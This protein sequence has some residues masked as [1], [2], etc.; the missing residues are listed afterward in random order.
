MTRLLLPSL[1][2]IALASVLLTCRSGTE[3]LPRGLLLSLA[4][5]KK[6]NA[7]KPVPLP[8]RLGILRRDA[9][10][11]RYDTIDDPDSNV[12]HKA[13][14]YVPDSGRS[15]I[16][17]LGGTRA[18]LKLWRPGEAPEVLW[19]ADFGGE[20]SRMRDAEPGDLFGDGTS[21]LAV[22]THDQGVV[23]IVRRAPLG[24]WEVE[25]L[26]RQA[27]TIVHEIEVGDIDGDGTLEIYSTPSSR[28]RLDGKPQPGLVTRYIPAL[29][30]GRTIVADL[31]DRHA[32]EILVDD[33]NGDG[34]DELYV[35]V[36]AVSGG[37]VE[38][39]R[40]DS[41]TDPGDGV[42]IANLADKLCRFLTSG[43]PD[44][45][46]Q[47]EIVAATHKSGLWLLEPE[48]RL[49]E[50]WRLELIDDDSGGF[51][52]ATVLADLDANGVDELYVASDDHGEVRRYVWA[53][54]KPV[55]DVIHRHEAD[56]GG[57]TW[58]LMPFPVDL[59]P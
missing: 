4:V 26:D 8:A 25:E 46:G 38:I 53:G 31:G 36:E 16:V 58:N 18:I 10:G 30:E 55:R 28:N 15:G 48:A 47:K 44:G 11:W 39:R 6:N 56:S 3:P 14:V 13:M 29:G 22:A 54:G 7:G 52:H 40:Y 37:N 1:L 33:I 20:F 59:A 49:E 19:D 42:I 23:A 51:E 50:P 35:A 12:F 34:R 32:K 9:D 57:I 41:D 43:D 24:G 27:E 2:L 45:D 21:A 17:T 5:F